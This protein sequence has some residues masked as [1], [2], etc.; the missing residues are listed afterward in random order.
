MHVG[1]ARGRK[2]Q[3]AKKQM[4]ICCVAILLLSVPALSLAQPDAYQIVGLVRPPYEDIAALP[5]DVQHL[6][7]TVAKPFNEADHVKVSNTLL[8]RNDLSRPMRAYILAIKGRFAPAL[9][10][11]AVYKYIAEYFADLPEF[12]M[13]EELHIIGIMLNQ[14]GLQADYKFTIVE[15]EEHCTNIFPKY[16]PY[17][18]MI[19]DNQINLGRQLIAHSNRDTLRTLSPPKN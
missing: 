19:I 9:E 12:A 17:V 6:L 18:P 10:S 1:D 7:K 4:L 11:V 13:T 5:P 3:E 16:S 8:A 2:L 14:Y 15:L